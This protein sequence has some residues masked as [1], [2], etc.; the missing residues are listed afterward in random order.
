MLEHVRFQPGVELRVTSALPL[1]IHDID[2]KSLG[3]R[4]WLPMF[5][6]VWVSQELWDKLEEL[7]SGR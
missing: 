6:Y 7:P 3:I 5:D 4:H 1:E 2:G